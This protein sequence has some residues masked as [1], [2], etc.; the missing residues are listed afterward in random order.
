MHSVLR[1]REIRAD[2]PVERLREISMHSVFCDIVQRA[3]PSGAVFPYLV[4]TAFQFFITKRWSLHSVVRHREIRA[5]FPV[6]RRRDI[7]MHS[8]F[9]D[10]VQRAIP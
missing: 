2:F 6:E 7:S 5:D 1:H 3:I 8:V 10:T 4:S 9:Y